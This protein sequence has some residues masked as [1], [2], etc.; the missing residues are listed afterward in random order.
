MLPKK[1]WLWLCWHYRHSGQ[2]HNHSV[3]QQMT[4]P[5]GSVGVDISEEQWLD[6]SSI[7]FATGFQQLKLA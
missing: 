1:N 4:V 5:G 6:D 7:Q 3:E 2:N